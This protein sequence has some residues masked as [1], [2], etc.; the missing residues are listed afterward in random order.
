MIICI[1]IAITGGTPIHINSAY[2]KRILFRLVRRAFNA[3]PKMANPFK[4]VWAAPSTISSEG[5]SVV[6]E[7]KCKDLYQNEKETIKHLSDMNENNFQ[8]LMN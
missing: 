7:V 8:I 4:S 2:T 1:G 5:G 3:V 6:V